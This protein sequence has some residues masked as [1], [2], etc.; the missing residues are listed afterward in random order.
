MEVNLDESFY[1]DSSKFIIGGFIMRKVYVEVNVK[2]II[3][4]NDETG[5]EE[6]LSDMTY[7]FDSTTEGADITD[8]EILDWD[9]KDSK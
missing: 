5:I 1:Q 8:T 2:L 7:S 4:S 9:I 6:V 3:D